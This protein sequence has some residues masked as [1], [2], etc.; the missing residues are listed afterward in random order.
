MSSLP[1]SSAARLPTELLEAAAHW[2]VRLNDEQAGESEQQA[3]Q[4]WL[5]ADARH[6]QAWQ[7]MQAL[8][9]RLTE[10]SGR[11]VAPTLSEARAQRR[12]VN[13]ILLAL[14]GTGLLGVASYETLP[15]QSWNADYRTRTGERRRVQLADGGTLDINT[16][17]AVDVNYS[18]SVRL[19]HLHAGEILVQTAPDPA[20]RPFSVRTA[21]G[22]I[23]ALGTRFAVRREGDATHVAVFEHAVQITPQHGT[24]IR[25]QAGQQAS[26]TAAEVSAPVAADERQTQ[27][28]AGKLIA[29]DQRLEDFVRELTRYRP[30]HLACDPAVADLRISGAFRLHDTDA[31]LANLTASLPVRIAF[32]T[33]YWARIEAL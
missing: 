12:R 14:I 7:Q 16:A 18:A 23:L 24:A 10:V 30:G 29:I 9:R 21:Q 31:I 32:V 19:L 15:W 1:L 33:R 4:R 26:F 17:S 6:A 27:W 3:W 2:Y 13:G 11:L 5:A 25:L 20:Q 8:E 22:E 28:Q